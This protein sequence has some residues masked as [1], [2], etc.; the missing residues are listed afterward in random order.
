MRLHELGK[1]PCMS[2]CPL[3]N[4]GAPDRVKSLLNLNTFG[5]CLVSSLSSRPIYLVSS[6]ARLVS[7][8]LV[9]SIPVPCR[10]VFVLVSSLARLVSS[11]L[12]NSWTA[13]CWTSSCTASS[14]KNKLQQIELQTHNFP[15]LWL[16]FVVRTKPSGLVWL[17][18]V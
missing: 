15:S 17:A 11:R 13:N 9:S 12:A 14:W 7:S 6:L 5:S 2:Q 16:S 3:A 1:S 4:P 10:P 8:H 18:L